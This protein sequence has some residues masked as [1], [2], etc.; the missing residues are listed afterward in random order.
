MATWKHGVVSTVSGSLGKLNS[1]TAE[2]SSKQDEAIDENGDVFDRVDYDKRKKVT[3]ELV[4]DG[5]ATLPVPGETATATLL[6]P[7]ETIKFYVD[8]VTIT[9]QS[10]KHKM[11][12][13]E[14]TR[15]IANA[16]P[17]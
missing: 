16:L 6:Y 10:E 3:A 14:G 4:L 2:T 5:T 17:A 1:L 9:E 8:R 13:I 7:S 15:Y 12:S 11:I